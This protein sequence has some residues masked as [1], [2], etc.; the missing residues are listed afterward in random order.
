MTAHQRPLSERIE[1][2]AFGLIDVPAEQFAKRVPPG[3]FK[4]F[5]GIALFIVLAIPIAFVEMFIL[6]AVVLAMAW[7]GAHDRP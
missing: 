6:F 5:A 3:A 7:E 1:R 4:F 2:F